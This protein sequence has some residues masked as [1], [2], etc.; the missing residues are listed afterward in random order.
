MLEAVASGLPVV[1]TPCEGVRELIGENGI[2]VQYPDLRAFV[3]AIRTLAT[4]P[5]KYQA[6]AAAGRRIAE[7][8]SWAAVADRY[9]ECYQKLTR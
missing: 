6:M 2:L 8:F 7:T 3:T 9:I 5:A 1:T 4:D